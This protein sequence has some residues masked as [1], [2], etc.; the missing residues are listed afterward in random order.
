MGMQE[1]GQFLSMVGVPAGFAFALLVMIWRVLKAI[2]PYGQDAYERHAAL[3]D[4]LEQS[5]REQDRNA[6][7]QLK[8][9]ERLAERVESNSTLR[10]VA[11]QAVAILEQIARRLQID[12]EDELDSMRRQLDTNESVE[13]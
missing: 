8:Q 13:R 5:L 10:R 11:V 7:A 12:V 9:L 3:V 2:A 6:E 1:I 4:T